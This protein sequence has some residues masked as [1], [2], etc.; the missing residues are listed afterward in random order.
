MAQV[1]GQKYDFH[2]LFGGYYGVRGPPKLCPSTAKMLRIYV[3]SHQLSSLFLSLALKYRREQGP[4]N[5]RN[6]GPAHNLPYIILGVSDGVPLF[7]DSLI[8]ASSKLYLESEGFRGLT[9]S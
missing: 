5:R 7:K 2:V 9:V 1:L 8:R 3:G 4:E 6:M